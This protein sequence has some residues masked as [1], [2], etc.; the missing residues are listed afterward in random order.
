MTLGTRVALLSLLTGLLV[1]PLGLSAPVPASAAAGTAVPCV[2]TYSYDG[3]PV[4]LP[5]APAKGEFRRTRV[6]LEVPASSNVEDV[7]VTYSI[8]HERGRHVAVSLGS[9]EGFDTDLQVSSDTRPGAQPAPLTFDDQASA[10]FTDG[11]GPGRYRPAQPFGPHIGLSVGRTWRLLVD[12]HAVNVAGSLTS[13]S[14]T[15]TRTSCDEDADGVEDHGD[16]CRGVANPDQADQDADG[17]GDACDGDRDGDGVVV[18][19]NCPTLA[20]PGQLDSDGDGVGNDCDLDDDGDGVADRDDGCAGVTAGTA[21]GCPSASRT[22]TLTVRRAARKLTGKIKSDLAACRTDQ[23]VSLW[24]KRSGK[25]R[26]LAVLRSSST[27]RYKVRMPRQAGKYYT[28]VYGSYVL[29]AAECGA[30]RS[31]VVR[32]RRR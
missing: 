16:N 2:V 1:V 6:S 14:V 15:I 24:Q 13:W 18:G 32:V 12:N 23:A 20:N 11:A 19:D 4:D 21:T 8:T 30:D 17:S 9:S 10:L 28:R 3:P 7:D 31:R 27:G 22:A 5:V 26:R 29:G 25:D